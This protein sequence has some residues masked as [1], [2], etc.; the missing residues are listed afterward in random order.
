MSCSFNM[1]GGLV[2]SFS[3]DRVGFELSNCPRE[4][5]SSFVAYDGDWWYRLDLMLRHSR[6]IHPT[7]V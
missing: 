4:R 3:F 7:W 1:S 5:V 6:D 2:F